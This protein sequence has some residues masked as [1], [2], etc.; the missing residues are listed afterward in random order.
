MA[1][2][3]PAQLLETLRSSRVRKATPPTIGPVVESIRKGLAARAD[4]S[5]GLDEAWSRLA[6]AELREAAMVGGLSPGG[7]L[8]I[9]AQGAAA[10]FEIEVWLRSGGLD[11]LRQA[12]TR[13]LR[14]VK[15]VV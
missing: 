5:A 10:R 1:R 6:P 3:S 4:A 13:S 15:V 14:R 2:R 8:T 11:A 9:R 7:V 12:C